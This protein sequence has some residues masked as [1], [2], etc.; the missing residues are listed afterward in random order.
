MYLYYRLNY[1]YNGG[2][3]GRESAIKFGPELAEVIN[4]ALHSFQHQVTVRA[5][6]MMIQ[7]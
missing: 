4:S 7:P 6:W 3:Q 5:V 1:P 2:H